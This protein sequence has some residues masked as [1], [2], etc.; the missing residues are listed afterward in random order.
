LSQATGSISSGSLSA[1][2]FIGSKTHEIA[3][4]VVDT[5]G[6]KESYPWQHPNLSPTLCH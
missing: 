5:I 4:N 6:Y 2:D 3:G 1:F